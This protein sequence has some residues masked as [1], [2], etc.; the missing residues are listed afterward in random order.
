M[1]IEMS[2]LGELVDGVLDDTAGLEGVW[3]QGHTYVIQVTGEFVTKDY[4]DWAPL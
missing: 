2:I 3:V 4:L 1:A